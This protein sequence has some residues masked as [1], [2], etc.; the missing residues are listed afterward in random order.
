M[1]DIRDMN[2]TGE[3]LY[4]ILEGV[5]RQAVIDVG[6]ALRALLKDEW[7][8]RAWDD[9]EE[10]IEYFEGA[11]CPVDA[12]TMLRLTIKKEMTRKKLTEMPAVWQEALALVA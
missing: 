10:C 11:L 6:Y 12:K 3:G 9:L 5:A 2:L 1:K 7:N 8:Y 4:Q